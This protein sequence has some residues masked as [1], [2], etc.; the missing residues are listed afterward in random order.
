MLRQ[1]QE[2]YEWTAFHKVKN[3]DYNRAKSGLLARMRKDNPEK[4]WDEHTLAC[5]AAYFG[6]KLT[7]K[8]MLLELEGSLDADQYFG[9]WKTYLQR[10]NACGVTAALGGA[11]SVE[12]EGKLVDSEA[13]WM[14]FTTD[15]EL[16]I[17][18]GVFL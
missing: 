9:D 5:L 13:R 10:R 7:E 17:T 4:W 3:L 6:D 12:R 2:H 1:D 15:P 8:Q 14:S 11:E 18:A 16:Y